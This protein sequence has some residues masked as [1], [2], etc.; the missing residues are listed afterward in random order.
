MPI[1][2]MDVDFNIHVDDKRNQTV[3]DFFRHVLVRDTARTIESLLMNGGLGFETDSCN[4]VDDLGNKMT[5]GVRFSTYFYWN[6]ITHE[7]YISEQEFYDTLRLV[8]ECHLHSH[9]EDEAKLRKIFEKGNIP[10]R[11]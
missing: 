9:P 7:V 11:K 6:D 2:S 1:I 3:L 8:V 5:E 10:Y 4:I